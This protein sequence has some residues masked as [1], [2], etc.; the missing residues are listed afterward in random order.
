MKGFRGRSPGSP[1]SLN[2]SVVIFVE[3]RLSVRPYRHDFFTFR[4]VVPGEL[5]HRAAKI[6]LTD[7]VVAG[8]HR[9]RLPTAHHF[10]SV[11]IDS[12]ANQISRSTSA[13]VMHKRARAAGLPACSRPRLPEFQDGFA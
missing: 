2:A 13:H 1:F 8:Q 6:R 4:F 9:V 7:N 5:L 11:F 3:T 12:T 10:H